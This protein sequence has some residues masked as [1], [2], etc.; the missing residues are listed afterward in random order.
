MAFEITLKDDIG[1]EISLYRDLPKQI[2]VPTLDIN[3]GLLKKG[4]Y[5]IPID[6]ILFI[7]EI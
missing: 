1:N 3:N 5:Y 7:E 4:S 2:T 6:H